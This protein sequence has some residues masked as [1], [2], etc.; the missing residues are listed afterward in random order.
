[1][2]NRILFVT[3]ILLFVSCRT[4]RGRVQDSLVSMMQSKILMPHVVERIYNG[5]DAIL[6]CGMTGPAELLVFVDSLQ[7]GTCQISK[8]YRFIDII[9]EGEGTGK[10][11]VMFLVSPK[12]EDM[13][14]IR[15]HI[16]LV[17]PEYPIYIDVNHEFLKL[18]PQI[19]NDV[20]FHCMLIGKEGKPLLVG[21]PTGS[22]KMMRLF[23]EVINNDDN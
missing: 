3:L 19:P 13:G 11:N 6:D 14:A 22:E 9:K 15:E 1:M 18:N 16:L 5:E 17:Q 2:K 21:D 23:R 8:F 4:E 10:Y 20:R 12:K 7:C